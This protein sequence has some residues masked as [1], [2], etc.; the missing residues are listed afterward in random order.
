MTSQLHHAYGRRRLH[1]LV[2]LAQRGDSFT[3]RGR[4]AQW[5]ASPAQWPMAL[6]CSCHYSQTHAAL[7]VIRASSR[8]KCGLRTADRQMLCRFDS[9]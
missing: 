6:T 2:A 3:E 5:E 9:K 1:G 8:E 4:Q 7:K